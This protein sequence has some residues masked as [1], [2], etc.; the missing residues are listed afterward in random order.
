MSGLLY[1][2]FLVITISLEPTNSD[3]KKR[4]S[5][6][7]ES[8]VPALAATNVASIFVIILLCHLLAKNKSGVQGEASIAGDS[9]TDEINY[10]ALT[11]GHKQKRTAQKKDNVE[12][13]VLYGAVRT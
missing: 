12:P 11:F 3:E 8:L 6:I 7:F 9:N 13:S 1:V 10:A 2:T 5:Q 4:S